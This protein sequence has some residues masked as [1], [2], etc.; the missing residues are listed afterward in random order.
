V[1]AKPIKTTA[2]ERRAIID[3]WKATG[4]NLKFYC[5]ARSLPYWTVWRWAR[6]MFLK[7]DLPPPPP[8]PKKAEWVRMVRE[9]GLGP[10]KAALAC[11]ISDTTATK[12][13]KQL[14]AQ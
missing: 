13:K 2:E 11:G 1:R 10:Y 4:E 12:W 3:D 7:G 14:G 5:V 8:H 6:G 9:E